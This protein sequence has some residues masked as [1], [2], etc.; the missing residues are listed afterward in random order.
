MTMTLD[1]LRDAHAKRKFPYLAD[2]PGQHLRFLDSIGAHPIP[3]T[4]DAIAGL[5]P[6][7]YHIQVGQC[8]VPPYSWSAYARPYG[9]T[10]YPH[11]EPQ[12]DEEGGEPLYPFVSG[13]ESE[14]LARARLAWLAWEAEAKGAAQ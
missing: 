13:C 12:G 7:N 3:A 11:T 4:L 6:P 5:M 9:M 8:C 2:L 1:E 10:D 14:I